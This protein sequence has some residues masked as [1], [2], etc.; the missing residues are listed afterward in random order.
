MADA[1]GSGSPDV[2]AVLDYRRAAR[3]A[4]KAC[5]IFRTSNCTLFQLAQIKQGLIADTV[6]RERFEMILLMF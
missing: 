5:G 2:C 4:A 6:T 3:D 1:L